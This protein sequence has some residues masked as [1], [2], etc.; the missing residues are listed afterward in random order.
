MPEQWARLTGPVRAAIVIGPLVFVGL[1]FAFD[2]RAGATIAVLVLGMAAATVVNV[3][4]RSDRHNAAVDCGEVRVIPDPGFHPVDADQLPADLL[5]RI[6]EF[7]R[8]RTGIGRVTRFDD[9]WI[10]RQRNPRDVAVVLGDD[11][12]WARFDPRTVTDLWAV[13]EYR[14]GRG[15]DG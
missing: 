6:G 13:A 3:K 12:G 7:G 9:G 10:V 14:A 5:D 2:V 15:R 4:N 11:G 8:D 1:A